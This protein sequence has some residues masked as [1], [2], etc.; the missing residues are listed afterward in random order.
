MAIG[1]L[2]LYAAITVIRQIVEPKLVAGQ[3]GLP[4][5]VTLIAMYLGL[6][7]FGVLGVFI[8]PIIAIMLKLLNDEGIITLWKSPTKVMAEEAENN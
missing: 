2:I 7:I 8:L 6:K 1:L 4:P 3:L 5:F